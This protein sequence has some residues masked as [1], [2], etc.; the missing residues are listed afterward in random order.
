ML[1]CICILIRFPSWFPLGSQLDLHALFSFTG[2]DVVVSG[3]GWHSDTLIS[4]VPKCRL[5]VQKPNKMQ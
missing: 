3:S 5:L 4:P 2:S 1:I